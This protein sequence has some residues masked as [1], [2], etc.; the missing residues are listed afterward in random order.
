MTQKN[1]PVFVRDDS[2]CYKPR[3]E[4][5]IVLIHGQPSWFDRI[6]RRISSFLHI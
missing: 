6:R 2:G 4:N 1:K 3:N 5:E